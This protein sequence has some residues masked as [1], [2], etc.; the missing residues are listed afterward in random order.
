MKYTISCIE[1]KIIDDTI[2]DV[3]ILIYLLEPECK[4]YKYPNSIRLYTISSY[5]LTK[6]IENKLTNKLSFSVP[7][8]FFAFKL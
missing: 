6:G 3:I 7:L 2:T 4:S 5:I 8:T 1:P